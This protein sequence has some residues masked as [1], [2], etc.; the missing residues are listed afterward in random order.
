M[1]Q[2]LFTI[3][4]WCRKKPALKGRWSVKH[5]SLRQAHAKS[6]LSSPQNLSREHFYNSPNSPAAYKLMSYNV[7]VQS[8][9]KRWFQA[10]PSLQ[11]GTCELY[12]VPYSL[13]V[14]N[15]V[16]AAWSC[17]EGIVA[18]HRDFSVQSHPCMEFRSQ[19]AGGLC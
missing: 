17:L 11:Q 9:H 3:T 19:K 2:L 7:A 5:G 15:L 6:T 14:Q 13:W 12:W 16:V 8:L 18:H 4:P 1:L 10:Y